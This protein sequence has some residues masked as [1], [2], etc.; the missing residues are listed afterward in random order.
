MSRWLVGSSRMSRCGPQKVASPSSRRAFSPPESSPAR[1]IGAR[2]GKADGAGAGADLGFR[3]VRHQPAQMVVGAFVRHRVRRADAGRN[4][5]RSSLSARVS[6]PGHRRE[7]AGEQLHQRRLAVAVGAEQRD[8]VVVVDAQREPPQHRP[9]RLVA[10]RDVVERDD[11]RRQRLR[12]RRDL[13]RPH[14]L[15]DDGR[16]RLELGQQ[17]QARLRLARLGGLGAEALD[18]GVSAARRCASCFLA[19]LRS[20]AW[21]SRRWRSNAV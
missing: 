13:D 19:S 14:L 7:P 2:A 12:R 18:E 21:R 6:R 4:R 3:R 15:G 16:D 5:R 20:S 11:R 10:D 1:R 8:A 17:L 9:A